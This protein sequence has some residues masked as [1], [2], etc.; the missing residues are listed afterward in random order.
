MFKTKLVAVALILF[1]GVVSGVESNGIDPVAVPAT[2]VT[3]NKDIAPIVFKNC[4]GCHRP[5]EVAPFALLTYQDT[6][7]HAKQIARVTQSRY[8]PPWKA[9]PGHGDFLDERRLTPEQ[10]GLIKQWADDGAPEGSVADLPPTPKFPEG[11]ALGEPD[12]VLK[13]PDTFT[14][15]AEGRDVFRCFVLPLNIDA[16]KYVTAVDYR[17]GNR[18]VVHHALFFLDANG[19]A[20]KKVSK[21]GKPGFESFGSPGFIP[22]GGLGGWAPGYTPR[23]LPE[24]LGKLVKKGS[25]LVI[26]IHFHPS[27]KEEQEQSTVGLYFTKKTPDKTVA[28]IPIGSQQINIAPGVKDYKVTKD[29]TVP[30]DAELVGITPHAHY[31][32][33][34]MK[35]TATLPDGSTKP[36]IWIKD[37]DF[38]WQDQYLYKNLI[39]L[40]KNT[41]VLFEY[42]YDNSAE[43]PRNPSTPPKL[44]KWG[45][46]TKDEMALVFLSYVA[47]GSE[48]AA[49]MR[50]TLI[51]N[52][53]KEALGLGGDAK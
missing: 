34:E 26:Q 20:R 52:K 2:S 13:M 47:H 39:K 37:W 48:D 29:F 44:V 40:P 5:G 12:M 25:D 23:A 33:K 21:D 4:T 38:S 30:V 11:W 7:K 19:A 28:S 22:T 53:V 31:L 1:A 42:T 27:G 6:F 41:K 17:P 46:E 16:D 18:K 24:G 14:L 32:C 8:M 50:R 43:N 35:V 49:K 10:I 9:E 36:L 51:A 45:H 15:Q 3:F